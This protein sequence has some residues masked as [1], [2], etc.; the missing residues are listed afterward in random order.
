[1]PI[2]APATTVPTTIKLQ[3]TTLRVVTQDGA[4]LLNVAATGSSSLICLNNVDLGYPQVRE[5][6]T[7][8]SGS[9]GTTDT[10]QWFGSR[11]VTT[12]FTLPERPLT[13]LAHDQLAGLMAPGLRLWLYVQR[14]DWATERRILVRGS[15]FACP[16][17]VM[18]VAQAGW[19]AP[20]G[21]LEDATQ[22]YVTLNPQADSAGG[23]EVPMDVP[24]DISG[25]LVA[26]A[27]LIDVG[28][29]VPTPPTID[30]YGPCSDPLVRCVDTGKQIVFTGL[31][32]ADGDFLHID[33]DSKSV[34]LN[35]D[36]S[37]SRYS[38]LDIANSD[39]FTL[40]NGTG[41]QVVFSPNTPSG[42]CQAVLGWRAR[43]V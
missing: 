17:G 3:A 4:E 20:G 24:L 10:S 22:S 18:R 15:T 6:T 32:I 43:Y 37:Q 1:V 35:G 28:G 33:M 42:S 30:I 25:G 16:P 40:P 5:V 12:Q 21:L 2:E 19:I 38:R 39:W 31:T 41:I 14:P 29:T 26:G 7:P 9:H 8:I 36:P 27:T 34:L 23:F 11:L 13:D